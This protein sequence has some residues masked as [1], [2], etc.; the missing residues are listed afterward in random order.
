MNN[1]SIARP[2]IFYQIRMVT[3]LLAIAILFLFVASFFLSKEYRIER[4][5]LLPVSSSGLSAYLKEEANWPKWIYV[6]DGRLELIQADSLTF[7]ILYTSGKKGNLSIE[8]IDDKN[9]H[10]VVTPKSN[11]LPVE[12]HISW[13]PVDGDNLMLKVVWQITG[14]VDAG[15]LSP[16]LAFWANDIAGAN[17]EKSLQ[18]LSDDLLS[19]Y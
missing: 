13:H 12:N 1:K 17:F 6:Q 10:F 3:R 7:S 4:S 16:Y 5:I 11:Q 15:F 2:A 18:R 9:V 14:Q 8:N 19:N